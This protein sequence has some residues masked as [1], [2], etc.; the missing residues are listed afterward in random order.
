MHTIRD[1]DLAGAVLSNLKLTCSCINETILKTNNEQLR[2]SYL[3]VLNETYNEHKQ[4]FD[5]MHQR[6]W[7]KSIPAPQQEVNRFANIITTM[8]NDVMQTTHNVEWQQ[9]GNAG[10]NYYHA[11]NSQNNTSQ[12]WQNQHS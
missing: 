3:H 5:L 10:H 7:H 4:V 2:Q 9:Q 8:Q 11:G 12:Q 6:G 1:K